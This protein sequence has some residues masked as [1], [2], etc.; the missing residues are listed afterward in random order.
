MEEVITKQTICQEKN[1]GWAEA[2]GLF[3]RIPQKKNERSSIPARPPT[4]REDAGW[5][6]SR[7]SIRIYSD[8]RH[9]AFTDIEYWKGHYY[10]A[11]R[12]AGNHVRP[13]DY[14][15]VL[16]IRSDDLKSWQVCARLSAGDQHDD[17]DP[18]LL[19]MGDELGVFLASSSAREAG[20]LLYEGPNHNSNRAIQS[21]GAF[22]TDG[23]VWSAPQP[24][25]EPDRWVWQVEG[26]GGVYY[27]AVQNLERRFW[28]IRSNDGRNWV[29]VSEFPCE[30]FKST[31]AGLWVTQDAVMHMVIRA[32]G[33]H[34]MALWG[35]NTPPYTEWQLQALNHTVHS[36]VIRPVGDT[37]WV[38]GRALTEQLPACMVPPEPSPEK[39][40]ALA[41]RDGRLTKTPQDW[42]TAVWRLVGDHL[43]PVV[44]F[45]QQGGYGVSGDGGRRRSGAG[46]LLLSARC[47]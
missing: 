43:E 30:E 47:G 1:D 31:E 32:L 11:F 3:P 44:V 8:G 9:N 16:V 36:P 34:D 20:A 4:H 18:A 6:T 12:N 38:A 23:L 29:S 7:A 37:L 45:A 42:H 28:L 13:G 33:T 15:D 14:G 21:Y 22:T 10:V 19:D 39:I 35:R 40:A 27:G 5:R 26:F 17:R 46:Q 25:Y 24:V 41:L 2:C